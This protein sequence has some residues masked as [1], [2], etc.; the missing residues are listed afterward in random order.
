MILET[1]G[2]PAVDD[3]KPE[4][5][6]SEQAPETTAVPNGTTESAGEPV[7]PTSDTLTNSDATATANAT[8]APVVAP[9]AAV[10]P[11]DLTESEDMDDEEKA[12]RKSLMETRKEY[13]RVLRN[14][15]V[16]KRRF[17]L[18]F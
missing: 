5:I 18:L 13:M 7:P 9:A 15:Q 3:V 8:P 16:S 14:A 11:P 12:L 4:A 1:V 10:E 6:K 2:L 17:A